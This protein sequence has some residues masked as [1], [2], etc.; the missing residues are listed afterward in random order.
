MY[1]DDLY[2]RAIT[3]EQEQQIARLHRELAAES[4]ARAE[5]ATGSRV[6]LRE[7]LS[8][9]VQTLRVFGRVRAS[10]A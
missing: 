10:K 6:L 3:N 7:R 4:A 1:I 9:V 2:L 8:A 5:R